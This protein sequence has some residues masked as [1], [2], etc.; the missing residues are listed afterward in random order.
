[1]DGAV[2]AS[3]TAL[4]VMPNG[5][6]VILGRSSGEVYPLSDINH[7]PHSGIV[8]MLPKV[9]IQEALVH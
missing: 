2:S 6:C 5:E 8:E 9:P 7:C 4:G 3:R 1:M